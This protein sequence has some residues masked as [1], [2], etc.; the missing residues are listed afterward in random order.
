MSVLTD[1]LQAKKTGSDKEMVLFR[2]ERDGNNYA[3]MRSEIKKLPSC[4]FQRIISL[5]F[6]MF[7]YMFYVY[8]SVYFAQ[9]Y[10]PT[11]FISQ[12]IKVLRSNFE[13]IS[14]F[15]TEVEIQFCV[16]LFH[17]TGKQKEFLFLLCSVKSRCLI[18]F[19]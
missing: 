19:P 8:I 1:D 16:L 13:G 12:W 15:L 18:N 6:F 10:T 5:L 9:L 2:K 11:S 3:I 17:I 4:R 7:F 14:Q